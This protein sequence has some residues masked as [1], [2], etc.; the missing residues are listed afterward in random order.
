MHCTMHSEVLW[1]FPSDSSLLVSPRC[2][3]TRD[4]C[5]STRESNHWHNTYALCFK[6]IKLSRSRFVPLPRQS[7]QPLKEP[8]MIKR[9]FGMAL[10]IAIA[11]SV[12]SLSASVHRVIQR[13]YCG[14]ADGM[15]CGDCRLY[16]YQTASCSLPE[17]GC[18]ASECSPNTAMNFRMCLNGTAEC[19]HGT[20]TASF[21]CGGGTGFCDDYFCGC[22]RSSVCSTGCRCDP[23]NFA[24]RYRSW[25]FWPICNN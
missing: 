22:S 14:Q 17:F 24:V 23:A 20:T 8:T 6:R 3:L 12:T 16:Q 19:R 2:K 1:S 13:A 11:M 10:L 21:T 5:R 7:F 9:L 4:Q 25:T 15:S 18:Y